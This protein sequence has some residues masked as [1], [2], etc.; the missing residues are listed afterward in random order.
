MVE[1]ACVALHQP[2]E[3]VCVLAPNAHSKAGEELHMFTTVSVTGE[4]SCKTN[5][6]GGEK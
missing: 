1:A 3:M 2:D 5:H 4:L 6:A